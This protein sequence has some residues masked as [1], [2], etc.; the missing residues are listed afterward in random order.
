MYERTR[1]R[2]FRFSLRT[3]LVVT[4]VVG[5]VMGWV[6]KERRQ[7][8]REHRIA[9]TLKGGTG[10][11]EF[12][13]PYDDRR[14][15]HYQAWWRSALREI[16]GTRASLL[17]IDDKGLSDLSRFAAFK[18]LDRLMLEGTQVSDL[19]P[20]ADLQK[21]RAVGL[22]DTQVRDL[23]PLANLRN[24]RSI[25]LDGTPVR[26]LTPLKGIKNLRWLI[27][28]RT[29]FTDLAPLSGLMNVQ[30]VYLDDAAATDIMPL[31]GL[32]NLQM[33]TI[34]NT[35]VSD[36]QLREFQRALPGCKIVR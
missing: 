11:V 22:R 31:A 33:L 23:T 4:L 15:P 19:T 35:N 3:L 2:W 1:R 34:K 32:K 7:S 18:S 12:L 17:K 30:E 5:A 26:D 20:L 29:Q 8:E 25:G 10:F 36:E 24:L 6:V 14:H 28:N 13:G 16:L 21:L 27:M 9:E